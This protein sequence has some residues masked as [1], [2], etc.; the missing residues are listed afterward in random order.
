M[1]RC[2]LIVVFQSATDELTLILPLLYSINE[3]RATLNHT[4]VDKFLKRLVLTTIARVIKE[5]IPETRVNQVTSGM[6]RTTNI[7]VD[8]TPVLVNILIHQCLLV[9]R[10]H[11]AQIVSAGTCK[12]RH[13]IQFQWEYGLIVNL[14]L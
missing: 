1:N 9:F 5:L 4:L 13:G 6:L 3:I 14:I 10:I 11:I 2:Y 8:V 7:E 12:S